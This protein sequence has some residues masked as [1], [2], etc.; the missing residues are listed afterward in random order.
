MEIVDTH[1]HLTCRGAP[2]YLA[3]SWLGEVGAKPAGDYYDQQDWGEAELRAAIATSRDSF[4]V[5]AGAAI[6]PSSMG[7]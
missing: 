2:P 5:A 7:A 6:H 4:T 3:N 1:V